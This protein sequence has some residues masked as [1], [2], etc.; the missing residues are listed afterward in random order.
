MSG[1]QRTEDGS[2][3]FV[4]AGQNQERTLAT[5]ENSSKKAGALWLDVQLWSSIEHAFGSH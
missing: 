1:R 3:K 4:E 5:D 2:N